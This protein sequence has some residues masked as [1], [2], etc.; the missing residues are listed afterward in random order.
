M[1]AAPDLSRTAFVVPVYNHALAIRGVIEDLK[2][3]GRPVIAVDDGSTDETVDVLRDIQGIT[4]ITHEQNRGKGAALKTGLAEAAKV[5]DW[6][7]TLDADGQ[8]DPNDVPALFACVTPG[9]RPLVIGRRKGMDREE[10]PWTS[11]W[12]RRFSNFWVYAAGGIWPQDSQSGFRLYP[13]PET[14]ILGAK[15]DRFEFEME[16]IV[17]AAWSRIPIRY[18]L[19]NVEYLPPG[20][21]VSH[22]LPGKD[23]W[24][25]TK[26]VTRLVFKRIFL[27]RSWRAKK[28]P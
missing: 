14:L 24:R 21:R 10:V 26:T 27:P 15:A 3:F 20:G 1:T 25:N 28:F 18:A 7:V 11:K 6:A 2:K 16:I 5:A 19:I 17:L 9:T 13:L 12:G 22:F 4:L 8:H 23:F